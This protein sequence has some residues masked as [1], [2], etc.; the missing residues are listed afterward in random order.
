VRNVQRVQLQWVCRLR[1]RYINKQ[2]TWDRQ[3]QL[4]G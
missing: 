3:Q 4:I 1:A 2:N